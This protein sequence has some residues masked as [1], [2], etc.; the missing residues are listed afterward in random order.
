MHLK[1]LLILEH[2]GPNDLIFTMLFSFIK[3]LCF[4]RGMDLLVRKRM[5][6]MKMHKKSVNISLNLKMIYA[7]SR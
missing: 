1:F 4:I 3:C 6:R 2:F 5:L 7:I